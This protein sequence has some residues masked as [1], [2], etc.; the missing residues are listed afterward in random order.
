MRTKTILASGLMMLAAVVGIATQG[1]GDDEVAV[2]LSQKGQACQVTN[3][4]APGLACVPM[5]GVGSGSVSIGFGGICTVGEFRIQKAAKECALIQCEKPEDCCD[6]PP[7]TCPDLLEACIATGDA[8]TSSACLQYQNLCVCN[9]ER[10]SCDSNRCVE[11][12]TSDSQCSTNSAPRCAGG[13]CVACAGD[14]D[15]DEGE[16]CSNGACKAP[17]KTDGDCP[18]FERCTA[19]QCT[20]SGCA[21]DREC[22]AATRNVEATCGTDGKCIVPCQ[23]DLECSNPRGYNFFSCI[24]NQCVYTGCESDKECRLFFT[25]PDGGLSSKTLV[26]CRESTTPG[27]ITRPAP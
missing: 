7:S 18:G 24:Q 2:R 3:D 13:K 10:V 25:G 22:V 27:E 19:G 17:C 16:Q 12:C 6:D 21:A 1:C 4:C 15:C 26:T 8:G 11:K 5:P 14:D 23:T 9:V 20:P